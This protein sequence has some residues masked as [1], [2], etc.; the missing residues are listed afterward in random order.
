MFE[1]KRK[2]RNLYILMIGFVA[3]V[4]AINYILLHIYDLYKMNYVLV[5]LI[6]LCLTL[7]AT[8]VCFAR[9]RSNMVTFSFQVPY[10]PWIP[11]IALF[12][13]TYLMMS[14]N[15]LTWYRLVVWIVLG[16]FSIFPIITI[17]LEIC[18]YNIYK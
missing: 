11:L 14:L 10:L 5:V 8:C 2:N 1:T 15:R 3:Q 17:L 7:L 18:F 9:R 13:N 6:I 16:E 12:F 4:V